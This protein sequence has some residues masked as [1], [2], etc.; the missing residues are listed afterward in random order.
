[1]KILFPYVRSKQFTCVTETILH[2]VQ[3]GFLFMYANVS[4]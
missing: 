2:P 3:G 4:L 1:M